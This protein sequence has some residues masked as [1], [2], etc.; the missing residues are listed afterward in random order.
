AMMDVNTKQVTDINVFP[1]ANNLNPQF[2]GDDSQ[3][4]FLS[5]RDG[6]RNLYRYTLDGNSIEQLTDYFTGISGITEYSPA[7]SVSANDDVIYS[8]YRSQTYT[9][10]NANADDFTSISV[11][12]EEI[13]FAAA[14]LPPFQ[15][16][17]VDVI[18]TNLTNFNNFSRID[19]S[20]INTIPYKPKFKLDYLASS[21]MGV[22][23]CSRYRAGLASGIQGMFSDI[24]GRNQIFAGLAINGEM[25]DFGGQ[26]AYIN[27]SS[28][29]NWGGAVSHIPFV[30]G[31]LSAEIDDN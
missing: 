30:S 27:Q 20:R 10:Y 28:R 6:F 7:L 23:V 17:G 4:Y 19:T 26:V 5:N 11:S 1:T 9:I 25:Y 15:N 12:N 18:N 14:M 3:I 8:Y 21:G 29:L 31:L 13:D 22:S 16:Y 24:L 2:S